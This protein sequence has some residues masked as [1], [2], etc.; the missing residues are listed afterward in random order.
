MGKILTRIKSAAWTCKQS[1]MYYVPK[2]Y[3]KLT[4]IS[5]FTGNFLYLFIKG[6]EVIT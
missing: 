1:N 2:Q 3:Q 6:F 4:D 5:N